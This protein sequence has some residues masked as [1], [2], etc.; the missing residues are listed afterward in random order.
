MYF[1]RYWWIYF[2]KIFK[3]PK[4][5]KISPNKTYSGVIGGFIFSSLIFFYYI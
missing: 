3:G 2:W 1:Y 4:L 5:T